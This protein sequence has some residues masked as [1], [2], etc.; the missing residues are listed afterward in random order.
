LTA[1]ELTNHADARGSSFVVPPELLAGFPVV[2]MHV[3]TIEPGSVR[4]NHF[5]LERRELLV[6]MADDTWS[7]H[8]DGGAGTAVHKRDFAGPGAVL[9]SVPIGSSHAIRN[10]G[11]APMRMVALTN[12]PYDPDRP[13]A[14][15][16]IVTR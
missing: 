16:R 11:S 10:D 3:A 1:V 9:V 4:G 13:D 8:W 6:V 5:H 2:D 12:G 15:P 7:L 14:H